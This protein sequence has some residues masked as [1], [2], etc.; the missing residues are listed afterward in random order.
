MEETRRVR[1][2]DDYVPGPEGCPIWMIEK[3]QIQSVPFF[4]R[5]EN[6]QEAWDLYSAYYHK[7]EEEILKDLDQAD[8]TYATEIFYHADPEC[9]WRR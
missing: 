8:P 5:A 9:G 3:T 7:H 6:E 4:V 1:F 2:T